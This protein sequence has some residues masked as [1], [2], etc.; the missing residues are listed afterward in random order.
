MVFVRVLGAI[1]N[2]GRG[3]LYLRPSVALCLASSK[4]ELCSVLIMSIDF[5]S[6]T[7]DVC[8][9]IVWFRHIVQ[10]LY[11]KELHMSHMIYVGNEQ[12]SSCPVQQRCC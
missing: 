3:Q 4:E 5:V 2:W 6:G 8:Q 1:T 12:K 7:P 11:H 9:W 10:T